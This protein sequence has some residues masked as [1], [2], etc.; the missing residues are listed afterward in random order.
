MGRKTSSL[1]LELHEIH[2]LR[3]GDREEGMLE[4]KELQVLNRVESVLNTSVWEA[5]TQLPRQPN[6]RS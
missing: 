1:P 3:D 5:Q 6:S 2:I 4:V